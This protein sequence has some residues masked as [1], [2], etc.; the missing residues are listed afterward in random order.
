MRTRS[1]PSS[2]IALAVAATLAGCATPRVE[3]PPPMSAPAAFKEAPARTA[4]SAAVPDAWWTLFNDPVLDG[5]E[6]RVAVDNENL[7]SA[8]A[9][10]ASAR[11]ALD[12]SHA[13]FQPTLDLSAGASRG[14]EKPGDAPTNQVSLGA[15]AS[16]EPDLWGRLAR[17][18]EGAAAQLQASHDDLAAATLSAQALLAQ[19]Y[20]ALRTAEAQAALL[21]RTIAADE[22]ALA[23]T[24]ARHGA[25][26]VPESDVQQ[27]ISQLAG[28]RAQRVEQQAQR[29]Q[30]EH[31]VAVLVGQAPAAFDLVVNNKLAD[32]PET[33]DLLPSTLLQR[34]PDIAAAQ[35]RVAAAYAQI[36]VADAAWFPD[37]TL[38]ANAGVRG[39]AI[40]GL[41]SRSNLLW[42][43]GAS[44]AQAVF[45]RGQ[46]Q[47]QSAQARAAAD[48][49]VAAYRQSVL[50]SLQEVEDNLV[51][52]RA[53]RDEAQHQQQALD[54]ARRTLELTLAQYRA[55]TVG[56]LDV[57]SA[58][59][60]ALN[61]ES[62][63]LALRNRQLAATNQLLKNIAGRW[64]EAPRG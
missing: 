20:F 9:A 12:A 53:L 50:T 38:S 6:A 63:L 58:Q 35:Q 22:R 52:A 33:P 30:L 27:A 2:I 60:T 7:K 61:S 25:G 62:S 54:A 5:L 14:K 44:L 57:T 34:R 31:A 36:G 11:A 39:S 32:V 8:L 18:R 55:G 29:A 23:I 46:R 43:A 17:A 51:L 49:A 21:E 19:T 16:W 28:H 13:A 56:Y 37:I 3:P 10:V 47:L 45:D 1:N 48:Q 4:S 40:A 15:A 59:T 64:S 42:S 24:R 41:L 26:V